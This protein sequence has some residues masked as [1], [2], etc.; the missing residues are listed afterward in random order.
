MSIQRHEIVKFQRIKSDNLSTELY[1]DSMAAWGITC[2]RG[3]AVVWP[4]CGF[5]LAALLRLLNNSLRVSF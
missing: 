2:M 1:A 4:A 5:V 3:K